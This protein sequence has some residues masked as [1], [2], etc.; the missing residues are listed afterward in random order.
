MTGPDDAFLAPDDALLDPDE[1]PTGPDD[2]DRPRPS[3]SAV[4][5]AGRSGTDAEETG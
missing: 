5:D 2:V 3:G 1:E 4:E